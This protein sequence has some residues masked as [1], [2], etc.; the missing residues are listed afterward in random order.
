M[1]SFFFN[2]RQFI[3]SVYKHAY[4]GLM[5]IFLAMNWDENVFNILQYFVHKYS[6]L[7][8]FGKKSEKCSL[9]LWWRNICLRIPPQF[10]NRT[11]NCRTNVSAGSV[12]QTWAICFSNLG[13]LFLKPEQSVSQTWAIC[14]SNLGNLF[15]KPEQSVFLVAKWWIK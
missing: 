3:S 13:N 6:G 5:L 4:G 14:F 15:L 11:A 8:G 12:S 9:L 1:W 2:I 10:E 7:S